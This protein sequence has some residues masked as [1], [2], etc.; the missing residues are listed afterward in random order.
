MRKTFAFMATGMMMA[1]TPVTAATAAEPVA[2]PLPFQRM[3]LSATENQSWEISQDEFES[4]RQSAKTQRSFGG[5]NKKAE[6][7]RQNFLKKTAENGSSY[8]AENID[9]V[10]LL[11]GKVHVAIPQGTTLEEV[12]LTVTDGSF[13]VSAKSSHVGETPQEG[14]SARADAAAWTLNGSGD[15]VIDV[16]GV[17]D[18][19]F[20]W[21]RERL[22]EDGSDTTDYYQYSRKASADPQPIDF[23]PDPT[24]QILR[25]QSYPYDQIE[26]GLK[27]WLDLS[28]ASDFSGNCDTNAM[29]VGVQAPLANVGYSFID[30]DDYTVWRN[31]DKPGSYHMTMDQGLVTDGGSREAAYSLSLAVNQGTPGSMHDFNRVT[32]Y[33]NAEDYECSEYDAGKVCP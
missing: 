21:K 29:S 32:F 31:V 10:P 24:V 19:L 1:L 30:C 22:L 7:V 5:E 12:N 16:T 14:I 6:Q 28:P 15:Y 18:A 23:L 25:I 2:E 33:W 4:A 20:L 13:D 3:N 27:S 8:K 9:S 11:G 26:S 17:G